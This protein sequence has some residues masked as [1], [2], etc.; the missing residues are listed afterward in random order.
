[1]GHPSLPR[2]TSPNFSQTRRL[3]RDPGQRRACAPSAA[4]SSQGFGEPG[5]SRRYCSGGPPSPCYPRSR[6]SGAVCPPRRLEAAARRQLSAIL[7]S[8][9]MEVSKRA[10]GNRRVEL[11]AFVPEG[12]GSRGPRLPLRRP[13]VTEPHWPGGELWVGLLPGAGRPRAQ[14]VWQAGFVWRHGRLL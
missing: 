7:L 10:S 1:M 11:G 6:G 2:Q 13:G 4:A 9:R 3:G 8:L 12:A 14:V 5:W